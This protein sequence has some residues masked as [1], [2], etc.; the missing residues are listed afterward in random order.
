MN[1]PNSTHLQRLQWVTVSVFLTLYPY[2]A[3]GESGADKDR[4]W[5]FPPDRVVDIRHIALD[6]KVNLQERTVSG[7]A[8]IELTALRDVPSIR[9]DA[10][11]MNVAQVTMARARAAAAPAEFHHD[12]K[13][14]EILC[15]EKPLMEGDRATIRVHYTV[16][17]PPAGLQFFGPSD[18]EPDVPWVMWSQGE[19]ADNRFW[20]PCVDHPSEFQS[21]E[22][23]VTVPAG[24]EAVSNGRL[25]TRTDNRDRTI[26]FHWSQEKPHAA[27]LV[28][29]V[30]AELVSET[31]TWR[32]RP[33]TYYVPPK[34]KADIR[35]SFGK[36]LK[37]LDFFSE[38]TGVEYPWDK[39]AQVCVEQFSFGG[40]EN[41]S[42]TTLTP[43]T[44]HN[45]RANLDFSSDGLVAHELAHQWFGDFVTCRDW[46]HGWLN[47]GFATYFDS[48][49]M[50][51]DLGQDEFDYD[52][53]RNA[54]AA[55][56]GGKKRPVVDRHFE[57]ADDMFDSRS[58]PK[59]A[60]VLHM[61][62]RRLGD[63]P[64]FRGIKR[65]LTTHAHTPVETS[66]LRKA[67]EEET[68]RSLERF[69][70]DW[71]ERPGAPV[72]DVE[73]EWLADDRLARVVVKQTQD[74]EPF[75]FPL[76]VQMF[77]ESS[78]AAHRF[79][80][81][82]KEQ[83]AYVP[84]P[85]RPTMVL[86]DPRQE[87]LME[88]KERKGRELW[89]KQL[90]VGPGTV[91]RIRAA[92]H[93]GE[94]KSDG[95]VKL[96]QEALAGARFWG[97]GAEI[98]EALGHAG[99][100][101]ARDALV[102][103]L[104]GEHPKVRREC[105][106]QLGSFHRD[107]TA[108]DALRIRIERGDPS[109]RVEAAAVAS[110]AKIQ[111]DGA[112]VFL[113]SLLSRDSHQEQIRAAVLEGLARQ[114]DPASVDV[115]LDWIARGK[116]RECRQAAFRGLGSYGR[117]NLL[118]EADARRIVDAITAAMKG[119]RRR[120]QMPAIDALRELGSASIPALPVLESL[121]A[122]DPESRVRKA[123]KE[124]FAKIREATPGH[125]ELAE[126]RDE[127]KKLREQSQEQKG[128]LEKL[129]AKPAHSEAGE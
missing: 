109:Y 49:F 26:T 122:N 5:R 85:F 118:A 88:L 108:A 99:G 72:V 8:M 7:T 90:K 36:T 60:C 78:K 14:I 4:P 56:E 84:L 94:S 104:A 21:T 68:G 19:T 127:L 89:T 79:D 102:E 92:R 74:G 61:L 67:F 3:F 76:E 11:D 66:D 105:A 115:L 77:G 29:L 33:V 2:G 31:E 59:G 70:Y 27:Y 112:V 16:A 120:L 43:R 107:T 50:E 17:N 30:V 52:M 42:A 97:V 96:L 125:V 22:M 81:T 39:Y 25:V 51:H 128:R 23:L 71:T 45:E 38:T 32:G 54:R 37:M 55:L 65:Y 41:T 129:E 48:L 53:L 73:F 86:V 106:E 111:P 35:R 9:L 62:R 44:L 34:H 93:F 58:Y 20:I 40:M 83:L 1:D 117:Q 15:G 13:L 113:T 123:A 124:A 80:I 100:V 101:K 24:F 12:G 121:A 116:P 46:S 28:T 95:D 57:H 119:E 82:Q 91:D 69:F 126:L 87:V 98:A 103:C 64:F 6:L 75:E 10:V 110:Y 18:A 47:E 114:P 63:D